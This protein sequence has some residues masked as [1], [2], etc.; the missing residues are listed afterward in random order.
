MAARE[1]GAR[2]ETR[3]PVGALR[4]ED[5]LWI[6]TLGAG[7]RS[8]AARAVVNA[9]GPWVGDVA[10]LGLPSGT[11][12]A[13]VRLVRGSHIVVPRIAGADDA[14]TLQNS[15]GR[16]VFILPFESDFT[17]IGTTDQPQT[18]NPRSASVSGEEETYLLDAANRYLRVPLKPE[19]IVWK[20]A[21]VRP[22]DDDGSDNVSAITR[23]YRLDLQSEGTPPILHVI[24][25][26]ITTYRKLAEAA[27]DL[28]AQYFPAARPGSTRTAPLPGGDFEGR[29]FEA[30]FDDFA[31]RHAGF[32][33]RTLLR[34]AHRYGT[35]TER[36]IDGAASER[37]LGQDFGAGLSA[38]E[39]AYLKSDEWAD[40]ADDILWRRTKTGLHIA[41]EARASAADTIQAY[42]DKL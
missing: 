5:G 1:A 21:G 30:W 41:P 10:R 29:T 2:I 35:R 32:E 22:L 37:D 28:L 16:V 7:S 13:D 17:L 33:R 11:R 9:A 40:A 38:R 6:V 8:V 20:F 15:D 36:V 19:Q 23:D 31:R 12:P 25:G 18:Q 27:L 39:V 42:V 3:T 34:L 4:V 14:Y 24:G 26:K